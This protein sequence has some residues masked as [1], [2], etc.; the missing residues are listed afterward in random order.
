MFLLRTYNLNGPEREFRPFFHP[1][2]TGLEEEGVHAEDAEKKVEAQRCCASGEAA[3][4]SE[5]AAN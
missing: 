2:R 4:F 1:P 5:V 3:D